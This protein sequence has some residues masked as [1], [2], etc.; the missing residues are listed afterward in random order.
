M[1]Q[2][3]RLNIPWKTPWNKPTLIGR[4]CQCISP[5]FWYRWS[6]MATHG[7][8]SVGSNLQP[9]DQI[10]FEPTLEIGRKASRENRRIFV[11][12]ICCNTKHNFHQNAG[13]TMFGC[14]WGTL[15]TISSQG[16]NGGKMLPV[17][18]HVFFCS[19]DENSP[20]VLWRDWHP[21]RQGMTKFNFVFGVSNSTLGYF[22]LECGMLGK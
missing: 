4:C 1:S 19:G 3:K 22:S 11:G 15:Q 8:A 14:D 6:S 17:A 18:L 21:K 20:N 10:W 5:C 7:N 16:G 2:R 13:T 12:A 9:G